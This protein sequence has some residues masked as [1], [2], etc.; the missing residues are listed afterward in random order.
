MA[1]VFQGGRYQEVEADADLLFALRGGMGGNYGVVTLWRLNVFPV[2]NVMVYSFK[3]RP[4]VPGADDGIITPLIRR[5]MAWM[6]D[7]SMPAGNSI[8][9]MVKFKSGGVLQFVGQCVCFDDECAAC[10]DSISRLESDIFGGCDGDPIKSCDY[11]V[12][13]FGKAMWSWAGCTAWSGA[14]VYPDLE[15]PITDAQLHT[16][17]AACWAYDRSQSR[18]ILR[19]SSYPTCHH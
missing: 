10:T 18:R 3:S 19:G 12:Q 4:M 17:M 2:W 15:G 5:Y 6:R 16:A 14:D 1:V 9:G 7:P 11:E 8:W 13:L